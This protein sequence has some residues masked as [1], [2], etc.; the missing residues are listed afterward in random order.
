MFAG[1]A[2]K[3]S[4]CFLGEVTKWHTQY[5]SKSSM[6]HPLERCLLI[7]RQVGSGGLG[8]R[9]EVFDDLQLHVRLDDIECDQDQ[10]EEDGHID[11]KE[12]RRSQRPPQMNGLSFEPPSENQ[13]HNEGS[14]EP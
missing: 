3:A 12:L 14:G 4:Q 10:D 9:L 2:S 1:F 6:I 5:E 13:S 11:A 8:L 7:D